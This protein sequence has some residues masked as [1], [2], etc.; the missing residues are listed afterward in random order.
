MVDSTFRLAENAAQNIHEVQELLAANGYDIS[1]DV[2]KNMAVS[3]QG[4][5]KNAPILPQPE[6]A[7]QRTVIR[8]LSRQ[9]TNIRHT[10]AMLTGA[11]SHEQLPWLEPERQHLLRD[12]ALVPAT[13][14]ADASTATTTFIKF[15]LKANEKPRQE[16]DRNTLWGSL[17]IAYDRETGLLACCIQH[18]TAQPRHSLPNQSQILF[19]LALTETDHGVYGAVR[20]YFVDSIVQQN[21]AVGLWRPRPHHDVQPPNDW[22]TELH[23]ALLEGIRLLA[24]AGTEDPVQFVKTCIS[25]NS[26]KTG[27]MR[28]RIARNLYHN[29]LRAIQHTP[30]TRPASSTREILFDPEAEHVSDTHIIRP[31]A[32]FHRRHYEW[33][34]RSRRLVCTDLT[35][36]QA[37]F[38][39]QEAGDPKSWNPSYREIIAE[40]DRNTAVI[41]VR[42]GKNIPNYVRDAF[43]TNPPRASIR[44]PNGTSSDPVFDD[45]ATDQWTGWMRPIADTETT[46]LTSDQYPDERRQP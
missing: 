36:K 40:L 14:E 29:G 25:P 34:S 1:L 23:L 19:E 41:A 3:N 6:N 10:F 20:P 22:P 35:D 39:A 31:A 28:H 46:V 8:A 32:R 24:V 2:I 45:D 26:P 9:A 7:G 4:I 17:Q 38:M 44:W 11:Q 30:L 21:Y 5:E 42:F 15:N 33:Q 13:V 18:S 16:E 27:R 12:T 37:K 43:L